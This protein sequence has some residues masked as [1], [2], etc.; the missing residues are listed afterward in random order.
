MP[1]VRA[2]G[3]R[4]VTTGAL[5][6]VRKQAAETALSEGAGLEQARAQKDQAFGQGI[7]E[8]IARMGATLF[9]DM[10]EQERAASDATLKLKWDNAIADWRNKTLYDPNAGAFTKKG[11]DALPLPE[12]IQEQYTKLTSDLGKDAKTPRQQ[13]I[14]AQVT[15][16]EWQRV[17][18]EVRRHVFGQIQEFRQNELKANIANNVD[19][20]IRS[21]DDPRL[22]GISQ[23]KA[24]DAITSNG[25]RLGLGK[26]EIAAQLRATRTDIHT[27]VIENLITK[28]KV[29]QA[30]DY[31]DH[32]KD[33]IAGDRLDDLQKKLHAGTQ[34]QQAQQSFDSIQAAGGDLQA[35]RAKAKAIDDPDVRDLVL[36]YLEHEDAVNERATREADRTR[37]RTLYDSIDQ[38]HGMRSIVNTPEWLSTDG[39]DR[40]AL[41]SYAKSR[42]EGTPVK[43]D[44]PTFYALMRMAGEKPDDFA[45]YNLLTKRGALSDSDFQ[46]LAGLQH[47]VIVGNKKDTDKVVA[48][49]MT[50]SQM[51]DNTLREH[52]YDPNT[53]DSAKLSAIANLSSLVSDRVNTLQEGGK[54]ADPKDVQQVIDDIINTEITKPSSG[55]LGGLGLFSSTRRAID[56][57]V[58]DITPLERSGLES[59][60]RRNG[61]PV[62]DESVLQLYIASI[63]RRE[64]N[65]RTLT[66]A[67]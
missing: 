44:Q 50:N 2:Y 12:Q 36:G 15:G 23:S 56:L 42:A 4:Q 29:Q 66:N 48:G 38:G 52:G 19:D 25:P 39:S 13:A 53:K 1:L 32:T 30:R 49:F 43:T 62:T 46:Q 63:A 35:Q 17:D 60:L 6:G 45:K 37:L 9:R 26:D 64:Q 18:L 59:T 11:E 10:Q 16:Q 61:R 22:V 8:P 54:R 3:A 51:L 5:P 55:M 58:D 20:A 24:E 28:G 33:Q 7:G 65:K 27:G 67:R 47:S 21:S 57:T 14:F 40:S 41:W 34:K 31:F